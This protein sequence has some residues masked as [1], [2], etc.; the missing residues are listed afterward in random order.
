MGV[1][2]KRLAILAVLGFPI[3]VIGYRLGLF[4][5]GAAFQLIAVTFVLALVVFLVATVMSLVQRSSNPVSAKASRTASLL[6]LLP[7][8]GLGTQIVTG[9]SVPQIHNISTD[10]ANP[11]QFYKVAELRTAD[12][13]PL[14][15][16]AA[17]LASIQTSAYPGV[18]TLVVAMDKSTAYARAKNVAE[19]LGWNIVGE[20]QAAGIIEATE[21]TLLW[22]FKDDV[23]I[24]ISQQDQD[25]LA[26]HLRSV[27]RVGR[28]D[29]GANA[30]RIQAFLNTFSEG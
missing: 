3:S 14:V 11:P 10:T 26:I 12:H 29:L 7:M 22:D 4:Q 20:D 24:R 13:N 27:S 1:W 23:V 15:Y 9:R 21:S 8:I 6:C 5:F 17:K 25:N 30:K 16:D 18:K 28:S 2:L 19:Q